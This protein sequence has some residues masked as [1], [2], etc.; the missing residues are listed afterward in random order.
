MGVAKVIEI[1]SGSKVSFED[2]IEQGIARAAGT[3]NGI[4]SA[5]VKEQS[6]VVDG[7]K[8]AEYRVSMKVTFILKAPKKS[9]AKKK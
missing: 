1:I 8:I 6:V 3:V 4:T 7:G 5:W 2:A 9:A